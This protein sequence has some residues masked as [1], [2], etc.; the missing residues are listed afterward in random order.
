MFKRSLSMV[1]SISMGISSSMFAMYSKFED[2]VTVDLQKG[3]RRAASST[4]SRIYNLVGY[5]V[6][7]GATL[8]LDLVMEAAKAGCVGVLSRLLENGVDLN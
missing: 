3:L 8:D 5:F 2:V 6:A 7:C 4:D 1:L